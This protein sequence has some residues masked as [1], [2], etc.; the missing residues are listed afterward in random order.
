[1]KELIGNEELENISGGLHNYEASGGHKV[2]VNGNEYDVV[3]V[4]WDPPCRALGHEPSSHYSSHR[5][6]RCSDCK[7]FRYLREL[8]KDNINGWQGYCV[9]E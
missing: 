6:S 1:M 9:W 3:D 4:D 8:G 7:D 5:I 2:E